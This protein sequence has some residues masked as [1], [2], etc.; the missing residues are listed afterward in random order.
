MQHPFTTQTYMK[1]DIY[2]FH[3]EA[4]VSSHSRRQKRGYDCVASSFARYMYT[5]AQHCAESR[6]VLTERSQLL[7]AFNKSLKPILRVIF[8]Q[9]LHQ[10]GP[11]DD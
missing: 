11:A 1:D 5:Y 9:T 3:T 8:E 2:S 6:S 10:S 4:I 7:D